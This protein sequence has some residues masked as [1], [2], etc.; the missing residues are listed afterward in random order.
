MLSLDNAFS[1]A[2]AR[3]VGG[4]ARTRR[5]TRPSSSA[6]SRSTGVAINLTY[7]N[8]RLVRGATRGD[9]RVGEDVTPNVRTIEGDPHQPE[10]ATTTRCPS[11][12]RCAARCSSRSTAFE[13]LNASLVAA[14]KAP[15]SNPRNSARRLAAAEGPAR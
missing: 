11:W 14:G 12:S 15:F 1:A 13:T 9:G 7:E 2:R 5:A 4:A 10:P 6:S 3:V 8:G